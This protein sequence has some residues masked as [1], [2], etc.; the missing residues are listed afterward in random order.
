TRMVKLA[1]WVMTAGSDRA[2]VDTAWS[3]LNEVSRSLE[4]K[5]QKRVE[6][7]LPAEHADDI[8]AISYGKSVVDNIRNIFGD[9][10]K[11]VMLRMIEIS[12]LSEIDYIDRMYTGKRN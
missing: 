5:D 4:I 9:Y 1:K 6:S 10:E 3:V 2:V 12:W 11:R 8:R 7:G